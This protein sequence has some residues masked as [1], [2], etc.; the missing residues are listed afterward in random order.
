MSRLFSQTLRETPADSE[1]TSHKLL[2][3]AGY[4]RQLGAGIFSYLPLARRSLTKI[5]NIMRQE[6][7]AIGGQEITMPVVQPADIWQETGRWY[8]IGDEMGRFLDKNKHQMVLAMTHEEVIAD[9]IRK[10]VRSYRQLPQLLYHIQTKWRDDP[11]PRAGLI[12]AREFTMKDSYSLDADWNGLDAQYDAHYHAYVNVFNRCQLPVITIQ[13]DT[14][15]MG[16]QVAHEFMYLTPIGEDT[17]IMCNLCGYSANRQIAQSKKAVLSDEPP[18]QLQKVAT[19]G[20]KTIDD[21]ANFLTL[22]T[23]KTAK[24]VFLVATYLQGKSKIDQFVFAVVRGD[25]EANETKLANALGA[26]ELRPATTEEIIGAGAVPGYASPIGLRN[27]FTVVDDLIPASTNLVSGA[28]EDGF[29]Y[30]NVNFGRDY[31]ADR[32][33]DITSVK[34]GDLCAKCGNPLNAVR[35][36]EVGNIFKLGTHFSESMGCNFL[37]SQGHSHPVVMGSYG[38]GSGRLL[39]CIAEQHHD[40]HG[41]LWPI[42]IAPFQI[43]LVSLL[44]KESST[45]HGETSQ[46]DLLYQELENAGMECLYDDR[47]ESPG[48]KFNDADLIGNPIRLTVSEKSLRNGGVEFKLRGKDEKQIITRD[49]LVPKLRQVIGDLESVR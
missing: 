26:I 38:I 28:N 43:H 17:I 12:R 36:V 2:L 49:N 44:S 1:V 41:L 23:H 45:P 15:F 10:E 13:S 16:G 33:A 21:L 30:V 18:L 42:T 11:R 27:V 3:R 5:E 19:P 6:I 48:V 46:A 47:S 7:D 37:D 34:E 24:A 29:H 39:A 25:M 31:S 8:K 9:L 40:E 14:G 22:P 20:T 32:I 35:G 4:I